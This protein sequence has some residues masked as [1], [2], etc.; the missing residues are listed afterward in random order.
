MSLAH[1]REY[2]AIPGPSVMPDRVLQAMHRPAPNIYTGQLIDMVPH[3][4]EGLK[5]VARTRAD[6]AIYIGNGH[7]TWEAS[8]CN[9]L[10][11]GDRVLVLATG[12]FA[13]G[14]GTVAAGLGAEVET[15]DFGKRAP[16]DLQVVAERLAAD[17]DHRIKAVLAVQTDTSTSV[18][19]DIA[20]L[21]RVLDEAG[22]P[23]LLMADCMAS[24]GCERFEMDAWGVDVMVAGCQKGL[25]TPPGMAFVYFNARAAEARETAGCVT[26]YWDWKNRVAPRIFS[27]YFYGTAPTHHLY[28]L[29]EA[30]AMIEEEGLEQVWARHETLARAVWAAF[31]AW[32][33]EGPLELNIDEPSLRSH[34]VTALRLGAPHGTRLRDWA[35]REAGV[36]LGIGLGMAEPGDPAWHGFFRIGHMGHVN[37][38]MILGALGAIEAGLHAL[39]IPHGAGALPAAARICAG[40]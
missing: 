20:G 32:G 12:R 26:P 34:A 17:K 23:A 7:A 35:E 10:S 1:G 24:L 6:C 39:D 27:E 14:W 18:R 33:A 4:V 11:R 22:H 29:R 38:H 16:V 25:M 15:L 21:R 36:T 31:E 19:N 40:A 5:R 8:L 13:L 3:L 2:L 9:V 37:A 28:G 30:L